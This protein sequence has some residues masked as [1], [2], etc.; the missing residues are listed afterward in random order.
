MTV[1]YEKISDS[2]PRIRRDILYTQ[3]PS[4]V[5]FH[6]AHGGF[7]LSGRS[8][9]KF[10]S[11][12]VPHLNGEH[13]I[14]D[15]CKGLG[16]KQRSM[17]AEL[18]STLYERGFARD[19]VPGSDGLDALDPRVAERFAPQIG[20]VDHY[21]G[22]AG[23]RFARFRDTRVAVL[24]DDA[25]AAWCALSLIRNG[26]AAVAVPP[27][28]ADGEPVFAEAAAE[29]GE[30]TA[31]GCPAA[32]TSLATAGPE[33]TWDE[34]AGFDV[35]VT[36]RG[37]RTVL[38][39]LEAGVPQGTALLPVWTFGERA[40]VGP[41][42]ERGT[43]GCWVCAALRL[44]ANEERD[45]AAL[46]SEASLGAADAAGDEA[47][48]GPLA[49]MLG[50]LVGYEVFRLRTGALASE[51]QGKIV[52]QDLDSLDVVSEPLLP[53]PRCPHCRPAAG[54][55]RPPRPVE[56]GN[57]ALP[58]R[59]GEIP[60]DGDAALA[61]L[62]RRAVLVNPRA[63][64]FGGWA[65][66]A[67]EQ[68][69]MKV[70]TV[71][72]GSG[73]SRRDVCAFD[74]HHVAGA[75][76]R[77]LRAAAAVYA[78]HVVPLAG[79][80]HGAALD[81]APWP[82]TDPAALG[83]ASGTGGGRVR[84]WVPAVSLC[85]GEG[86]L[87]PAGAVRTFG[88]F[89]ADREWVPTR[90]GTGVGASVPEAA[91][92]GLLGALSYEALTEALAGRRDVVR[93]GLDTL[94]DDAELVFL[95]RSAENLGLRLELLDLVGERRPVPV[96]LARALDPATGRWRWATGAGLDWREAAAEAV[97]DLL[98]VAQA[99]RQSADGTWVDTGDPLLADF[100][101]GTLRVGSRAGGP[102]ERPL[103]WARGL[104]GLVE[105]G[106]DA[107]LADTGS[108]DLRAGGLHVVR[109]VLAGGRPGER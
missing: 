80:L 13:T 95:V 88:T 106:G 78:E 65:D 51:T 107:L 94:E 70:A 59:T 56:L 98:G 33:P 19:V 77:A 101:A 103:D 26:A 1:T 34:L 63:G 64:V 75:R 7:N 83:T 49:A 25:V 30:L 90:A 52:V 32:F 76:L 35:V 69:P 50:N 45:A 6:N 14:G 91:A 38:R 23:G 85:T 102:R 96:L 99:D 48:T 24:G 46:W 28:A 58:A 40:V 3:T 82:R 54:A 57:D 105:D 81:A 74:V 89:N 84:H 73:G 71:T 44:G 41:L 47:L 31:D 4:G 37:P 61:E 29:A 87:L 42:T 12:I 100:D 108:D 21:V 15:I 10:A 8:A 97:R 9:Y 86:A 16:E 53:H 60:E 27:T 104:A 39:L 79:T 11:L 17:V 62:E 2:R 55:A 68:T 22:E 92:R 93:V 67:W 66:D 5:I 20:Y 43:A 72:L 109:V 36:T 18:V